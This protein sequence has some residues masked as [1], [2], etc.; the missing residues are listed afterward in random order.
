MIGP[1]EI[2]GPCLDQST[3]GNGHGGGGS[4]KNKATLL[5]VL[6]I[7]RGLSRKGGGNALDR[8]S[9]K[10][11]YNQ[12]RAGFL[13]PARMKVKRQGYGRAPLT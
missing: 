7:R 1:A 8:R 9:K 3:V 11:Y 6:W 13:L 2:R 10:I 5:F 4:Y 12:E